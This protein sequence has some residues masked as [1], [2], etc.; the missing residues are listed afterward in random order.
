MQVSSIISFS[1]TQ[2][3]LSKDAVMEASTYVWAVDSPLCKSIH[4]HMTDNCHH[5]IIVGLQNL[6]LSVLMSS[7]EIRNCT[8]VNFAVDTPLQITLNQRHVSK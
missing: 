8:S 3:M 7:R 4:V 6:G 1:M 2:V 5:S